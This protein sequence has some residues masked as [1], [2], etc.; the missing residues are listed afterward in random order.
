MVAVQIARRSNARLAA[1]PQGLVALFIGATSGIGQSAL[2]QFA[3]HAQA[4]RIYTVARP[5]SV[6]AHEA[7]LA[8][9]RQTNPGGTYTLITA[10]I[11]LVSEVDKVVHS[12]TQET[13]L[14]LLVMSPGFMAFEG[15]GDT[16]E[17]LD[18]SMTTRY[19]SRLR[20]LEQLAPLLAAGAGRVLSVLA[21]GMEG[22]LREN[23]L[24]LRAPGAW[25]FWNASVHAA[26]MGTLALE[27][28]ARANPG[29]SIVHSFPGPVETPGLER[30]PKFGMSPPNAISQAD[31]GALALFLAISDRYAV[32]PGLVPVPDG[33][34]NAKKTSGGIFLVDAKGESVDNERVLADMRAR[35]VDDIVWKH[36]QNVF[37]NCATK[38]ASSKDEL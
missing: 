5:A 10:D 36:T 7:F 4:P 1:V 3:E 11:S 37:A 29:L 23:D 21:G 35:S 38:V 6:P 30:A 32:H 20:A 33:L 31:G 8:T 16:R 2:Q 26:T 28:F 22:P 17:G 27:R 24:D 13:K 18:P 34:D 19:Y 15:R 9:L 12:V 14:D 25:S